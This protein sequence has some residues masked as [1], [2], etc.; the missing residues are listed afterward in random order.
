MPDR[1]PIHIRNPRTLIDDL[2]RNGWTETVVRYTTESRIPVES[3]LFLPSSSTQ[4]KTSEGNACCVV[5]PEGHPDKAY[6]KLMAL[7]DGISPP[8]FFDTAALS[9]CVIAKESLLITPRNRFRYGGARPFRTLFSMINKENRETWSVPAESIGDA[10][11]ALR[12]MSGWK[13]EDIR[14]V[15]SRPVG[16]RN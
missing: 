5:I 13:A 9:S 11:V 3:H 2:R 8:V 4:R 15:A 14:L 12:M 16:K 7:G 1:Y 6:L 10:T